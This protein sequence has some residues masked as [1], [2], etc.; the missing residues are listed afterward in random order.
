MGCSAPSSPKKPRASRKPVVSHK[1]VVAT[2]DRAHP[3][4]IELT[5]NKTEAGSGEVWGRA[6]QAGTWWYV[7]AFPAVPDK[8]VRAEFSTIYSG[9]PGL[10]TLSWVDERGEA[11]PASLLST[12]SGD[13]RIEIPESADL[14]TTFLLRVATTASVEFHLYA[15][16]ELRDPPPI[17]H[18][19]CDQDHI[20][21]ANP[22]CKGVFPRCELNDPDFNN[23]NCCQAQ[24][25]EFARH[26]CTSKVV[27]GGPRWAN[28]SRR[29]GDGIMMWATGR[30]YQHNELVSEVLVR[31]V[32][33][34]ELVIE[35]LEPKKV[36][37]PNLLKDSRVVL[38]PPEVCQRQQQRR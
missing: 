4:R 9:P 1:P 37:L 14:P 13:E 38:L 28:I 24:S 10:V 33:D 7:V 18:P 23:P 5:V 8:L 17:K 16:R 32:E 29:A 20:D 3:Q 30:L 31:H 27:R 19:P 12:R 2:D 21:P 26:N 22:N 6:P 25:C 36:D 11:H 15:S 34:N 35:I